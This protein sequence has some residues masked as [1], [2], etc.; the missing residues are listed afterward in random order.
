M[1]KDASTDEV[2]FRSWI[3]VSSYDLDS[4]D[5]ANY[6]P[7]NLEIDFPIVAGRSSSVYSING[8][9]EAGTNWMPTAGN[10]AFP[11]NFVSK[12]PFP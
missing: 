10:M 7:D 9:A 12:F 6:N 8:A 4:L 1:W 5:I 2:Y 3:D 11:S